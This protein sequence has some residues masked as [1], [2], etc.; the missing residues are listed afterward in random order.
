MSRLQRQAK[1]LVVEPSAIVSEGLLAVL[2]RNRAFRCLTPIYSLDHLSNALGLEHPDLIILNPLLAPDS[3]LLH[4]I[5]IPLL[6]LFYTQPTS[7][8]NLA[9]YSSS[10]CLT[11]TPD[12]LFA[13]LNQLLGN[14]P[15][16]AINV[17]SEENYEL[18]DREIEVLRC[19]AQGLMNKEI[20]DKLNISI[21]TVITHRKNINRKTGIKSVAG[22]TVYAI[23]QGI[24]AG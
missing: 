6:A 10:F 2:G 17:N 8:D 21:N 12:E 20:A 23:M 11:Q 5:K 1:I 9:D 3:R 16:P 13:C 18:S 14:L 7:C 24:I 19:V 4:Q 22:L 15:L